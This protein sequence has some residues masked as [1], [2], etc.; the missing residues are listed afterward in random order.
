MCMAF[1][2]GLFT[3]VTWLEIEEAAKTFHR[4]QLWK[5]V[6]MWLSAQH[7]PPSQN[8]TDYLP[9]S[10]NISTQLV[11]PQATHTCAHTL[12]L[13]PWLLP[14]LLFFTMQTSAERPRG[15]PQSTF[16]SCL[17]D[18]WQLEKF[19]LYRRTDMCWLTAFAP[20]SCALKWNHSMSQHIVGIRVANDA[21]SK[22]NKKH[23]LVLNYH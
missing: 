7:N 6:K 3:T 12:F 14:L 19:I 18:R 15:I 4:G 20:T 21:K 1:V 16:S 5:S 23:I 13:P 17:F 8:C 9:P 11:P 2:T 10:P 22:T